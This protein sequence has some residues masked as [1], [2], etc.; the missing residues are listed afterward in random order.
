MNSHVFLGRK[1]EHLLP[2]QCFLGYM[3]ICIKSKLL[4][5]CLLGHSNIKFSYILLFVPKI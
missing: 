5:G 4:C 3:D 1:E 2:I